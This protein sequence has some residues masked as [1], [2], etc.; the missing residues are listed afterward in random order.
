[1]ASPPSTALNKRLALFPPV[2]LPAFI[3]GWSPPRL[4]SAHPTLQL[5]KACV[6]TP[7]PLT[8]LVVV[9]ASPQM[10]T[11]GSLCIFSPLLTDS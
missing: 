8:Q 2:V 4:T 1:M 5:S 3:L 9:T 10:F 7:R 11:K 6:P